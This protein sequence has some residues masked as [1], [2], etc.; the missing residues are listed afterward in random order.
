M[1]KVFYNI[2]I[3][4][5]LAMTT[6]CKDYLDKSPLSDIGDTDPYKN[7]MNFQGFTDE[8]YNTIPMMTTP[9][10]HCCWN[11]GEDEYWQP[12]ETRMLAYAI[13][14]GNNWGWD[15]SYYS[16]FHSGTGNP[17]STNRDNKGHLWGMSW[18]GIRKANVGLAHLDLLQDATDEEKK[19]IKGQLLF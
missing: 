16:Y 18:Y 15:E 9:D 19:L 2:M 1:K 11:F 12:N 6:S 3:V 13:D 7:Y 5:A 17:T 4:A 10:F 8:L 14:H